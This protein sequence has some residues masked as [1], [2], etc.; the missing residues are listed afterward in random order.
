MKS[1]Q[2]PAAKMARRR[3]TKTKRRYRQNHKFVED[4]EDPV[5]VPKHPTSR[6]PVDWEEDWDGEDT[7]LFAMQYKHSLK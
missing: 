6:Q 7:P 2:L 3:A 4:F 5:L 1:L